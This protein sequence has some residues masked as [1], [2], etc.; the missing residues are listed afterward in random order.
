MGK[1]NVSRNSKY[2][3]SES[4]RKLDPI[5]KKDAERIAYNNEHGTSY[6]YGMYSLLKRTGQLK[7]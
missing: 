1:Y 3:K 4:K 7:T 5:E 6:S 2:T